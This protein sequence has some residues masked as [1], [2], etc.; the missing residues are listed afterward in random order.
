MDFTD[1]MHGVEGINLAC[2]GGTTP[3]VYTPNGSLF[4]KD[5]SATRQGFIVLSVPDQEAGNISDGIMQF[6]IQIL[7]LV[8]GWTHG[9]GLLF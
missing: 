8:I 1:Q 6:H 2:T 7:K 5:N 3:L 4:I 9:V